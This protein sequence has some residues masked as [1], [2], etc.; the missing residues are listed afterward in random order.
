VANRNRDKGH[1]FERWWARVFREE[2]GFKFC[3][4]SRQASRL[5]D[6]CGVDLDGIP[7]NIQLKNGYVKGINY[8][9]LFEDIDAKLK[10]NYMPADPRHVFPSIVIHKRGRKESEHH[11]VMQAK[12][13]RKLIEMAFKNKN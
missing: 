1:R 13:F 3:K 8:T 12:D 4:T 9:K 10:E 2:L 11:V 6:D 5:L 7:F